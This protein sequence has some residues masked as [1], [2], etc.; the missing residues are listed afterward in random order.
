MNKLY[1]KIFVFLQ[2][3]ELDICPEG[4]YTLHPMRLPNIRIYLFHVVLSSRLENL[5]KNRASYR[6][7]YPHNLFVKTISTIV[8]FSW[9]KNDGIR[10][11]KIFSN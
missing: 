6:E 8:Y 5:E 7:W 1:Q 11:V 3:S 10:T 9:F 2:S 4:K